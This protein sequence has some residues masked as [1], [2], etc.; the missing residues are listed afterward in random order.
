MLAYVTIGTNDL[1][2]A[3]DFYAE[4]LSILEANV[5]MEGDQQV[6]I[7]KNFSEPLI[8]LTK[9]F[10]GEKASVGNGMMVALLAGSRE[11]VDSLHAKALELGGEDEGEPGV[12]GEQFYMA[13]ARDLDGNKLAFYAPAKG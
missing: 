3:K 5:L 8:V 4:L 10:N 1:P 7:G 11:K 6:G 9:P 13:Y 12:R 2:K